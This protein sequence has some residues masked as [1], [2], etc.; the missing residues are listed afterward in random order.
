MD[1]GYLRAGFL[2][3]WKW[4]NLAVLLELWEK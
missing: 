3:M 1:E 4:L 2:G